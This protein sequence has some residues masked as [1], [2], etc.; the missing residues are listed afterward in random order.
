MRRKLEVYEVASIVVVAA[1][2]FAGAGAFAEE[3]VYRVTVNE[4][5]TRA[6]TG[7]L[8]LQY[9]TFDPRAAEAPGAR[10]ARPEVPA[11]LRAAPGRSYIVQLTGAPR[12]AYRNELR[13]LGARLFQFLPDEAYIVHMDA[14][15]R[16]RVEG[17]TYVRWVGAYEPV[18]KL[19]PALV[20]AF[21]AEPAAGAKPRA[22]A[23]R[24]V[25]LVLEKGPAM[26]R[27]VAR[28]IRRLG[29]TVHTQP[30]EG[31]D[32]EASLTPDQLA[33]LAHRDEI[34]YID[35]WFAPESDM[36]I[37]RGIS[38]ADFL[39]TV[40]GYTG[41][42]VRGEVMDGGLRTTHQD[43]RARPPIIHNRNSTSIGHGTSTYGEIFGSGAAARAARGLL[44]DGQGIF[45]VHAGNR[46]THTRELVDPARTFRAVFQSNSWGSGLTTS[47][48]ST[49]AA[50]DDIA[51]D[52]DFLIV[53]S[54][55][56]D[57]TRN[58]RPQAWAKNVLSVGG[59]RH[60]NTLSK[61]DDSWGGGASIGP[62]ADGRVKPDLCH[63]YDSIRT[64]G[65][66]SDTAYTGFGGT[67]GA[68]PIIAGYSGLFFQMWADGVFAGARGQNRDVFA[69]RPHLATA[70]ALLINSASQYSF[71]GRTH[72]LTRV[73][74]GWGM[75]DVRSL[76]ELARAKNF[77]LPLLVDETAVIRR[78]ETHTYTLSLGAAGPLRVTLVYTDPMGSPGAARA[79]V[80]DLSLKATAPNGTVYWG[81]NGLLDGVWSTPGGVSNKIDT[82]ENVFVQSAAAG[83][84]SIQ[85]IAD[86]VVQDGHVE[87]PAV[88]A[89][90]ALVATTS[91]PVEGLGAATP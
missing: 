71:T 10:A 56:N 16:V 75:V 22:A 6:G 15:A 37:A 31:H 36:D 54:Q 30:A 26:K 21:A 76:Y 25:I 48:T 50:L 38:G 55:S 40:A 72:D 82:V 91:A 3:P 65:S 79:R 19:E 49:S 58:S 46:A 20:S 2:G 45:A 41:R 77:R 66:A 85:V 57:G 32:L 68:T 42:G 83:R 81:N 64:T 24:Y 86:E 8:R 63:F 61:S 78:A 84:W 87:T 51:F 23:Q 4:T 9:G 1:A 5:A 44:P 52:N 33:L 13:S 53:Q 60:R 59:V 69:S 29:G 11:R 43:F 34:L 74:Q 67:S 28:E 80:N 14:A 90:Y 35:R 73:H 7:L 88:D 17:L 62:A 89:D 12:E 27:T 18:Y 47:Y 39:E 70:K